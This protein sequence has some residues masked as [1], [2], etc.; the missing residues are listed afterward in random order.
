MSK[1]VKYRP[2]MT[3]KW[4]AFVEA[5]KNG[6]F[7]FNR[8]YMDYHADR[9]TDNSLVFTN[10]KGDWEALLP[11]NIDSQNRL[12]SHDGLTYGGFVM[13]PATRAWQPLEWF[14]ALH[15]YAVENSI[16]SL[17]YR[18]TPYIYHTLPA[19]EDLY[20]LFRNNAQLEVCNLS[21]AVKL[22]E[23]IAS[24]LGKRAIKRAA[25]HRITV[26]ETDT[27]ADFWQII[28]D[29]RK[30]RHNIS[31]VHTLSEMQLLRNRFPDNIK[32]YVAWREGEIIA[33][34]VVYVMPRSGVLHLQYAAAAEKAQKLYAVDAIYHH[35]VFEALTGYRYFDFG[36]SNE[37][38]GRYLNTNMTDHKEEFGARS[39]AYQAFR[40]D[41]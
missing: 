18:P 31:P 7:L 41:F 12:V 10:D 25:R 37:Q 8:G 4:D 32:L 19:D 23:G 26:E 9:F 24:R 33:G 35:I 21:S 36:I 38:R 5:S 15:R 16:K 22:P 2:D 11:A 6:T 17:C 1:I 34:A 39:V 20:A 3:R 30:R 29:D 13:L 14:D 40:L 28:V 27:V